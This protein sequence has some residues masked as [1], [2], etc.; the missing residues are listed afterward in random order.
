TRLQ[1]IARKDLASLEASELVEGPDYALVPYSFVTQWRTW[2][3]KPLVA[4][5]PGPVLNEQ[6][7]C[8]HNKLIVDP[9]EPPDAN[10]VI[11][12]IS[13]RDWEIIHELYGGGPLIRFTVEEAMSDEKYKLL[14]DIPLCTDCRTLRLSNLDNVSINV[15][16]LAE[17]ESLPWVI[18]PT[19]PPKAKP[20]VADSEVIDIEDTDSESPTLSDASPPARAPGN[21]KRAKPSAPITYGRGQRWSKRLRTAAN[22]KKGTTFSISVSEDDTVR[23]IKRKIQK[24]EDVLPFYQKLYLKTVELTDDSQTVS[25]IGL[26]RTDRLVLQAIEAMDED[27]AVEWALTSGDVESKP[28]R[29]RAE[30]RAFG[31]TLLDGSMYGFPAPEPPVKAPGSSTKEPGSSGSGP[32]GDNDHPMISVSIGPTTPEPNKEAADSAPAQEPAGNPEV[33][34]EMEDSFEF[35]TKLPCPRCTFLNSADSTCCMICEGSLSPG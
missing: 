7:I 9:T 5:R 30:G 17:G 3:S 20:K 32:D 25:E 2:I 24:S 34:V 22:T 12:A 18:E 11:C 16:R 23:D 35:V 10:G 8:S 21:R 4:L 13:V 29:P 6:F 15:Y 19:T 14:S 33:N 27:A 1:G 31:G 28:A 26:L